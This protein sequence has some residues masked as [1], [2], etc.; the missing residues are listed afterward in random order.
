MFYIYSVSYITG[1]VNVSC[2]MLAQLPGK[3]SS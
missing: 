1:H 2:A 3:S